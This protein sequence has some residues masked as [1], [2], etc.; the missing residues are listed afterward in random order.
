MDVCVVGDIVVFFILL[1]FHQAVRV[2]TI[3]MFLKQLFDCVTEER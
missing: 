3:A 1:T 2:V